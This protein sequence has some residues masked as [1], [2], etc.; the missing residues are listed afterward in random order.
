MDI[1]FTAIDP[2]KTGPVSFVLV[3]GN[4]PHLALNLAR[5][6]PPN[7]QLRTRDTDGLFDAVSFKHYLV[8]EHLLKLTILSPLTLDFQRQVDLLK[9]RQTCGNAAL[10]LDVSVDGKAHAVVQVGVVA[11]GTIPPHIAK[12][13]AFADLTADLEAHLRVNAQ[14]QGTIDTGRKTLFKMD[15][16]GFN[17]PGIFSATP[18]LSIDGHVI[19]QL[20]ISMNLDVGIGYQIDGLQLWLP[21]SAGHS[22]TKSITRKAILSASP[23]DNARG[24]I[25][26][27]IL[28][29]VQLRLSGLAGQ[30]NAAASLE[31]DAFAKLQLDAQAVTAVSKGRRG[32]V[33]ESSNEY[34]PPYDR[35]FKGCVDFTAGLS[36]T[37]KGSGNILGLV[38]FDKQ[39]SMFNKQF[40]VVKKCWNGGVVSRS[41]ST[42]LEK[43]SRDIG[44]VCPKSSA[45]L[46]AVDNETVP[47]SMV[48]AINHRKRWVLLVLLLVWL[49]QFGSM[50][51]SVSGSD[52]IATDTSYSANG[53]ICNL[54]TSAASH[55]QL[56][57][58]VP[59]VIFDC[60]AF[61]LTF[62]GLSTP[63]ESMLIGVAPLLPRTSISARVL[64]DG[65]FYF[66]IL[67]MVNISWAISSSFL[68]PD[69][70]NIVHL[71]SSAF[72]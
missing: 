58:I 13:G 53:W 56:G 67:C 29:S 25:E 61:T 17:V 63:G 41:L 27:H 28:P 60:T 32:V 30:I 20:N 19:A 44:P 12:F 43:R 71:P 49:G 9:L 10:G 59:L 2:M 4:T 69:F 68:D 57:F 35:P 64:R 70:Q 1:D 34:I 16:D 21:A 55:F 18:E 14:L 72:V 8:Y 52:I 45:P 23:N 26:G 50:A 54:D 51:Y 37:G 11:S 39:I 3:G 46:S 5:T 47:A 7:S 15:I 48:Y 42:M 62:L 36:I 31:V 65:L 22:T 24:T 40:Q 6:T 33:V 66:L 38:D